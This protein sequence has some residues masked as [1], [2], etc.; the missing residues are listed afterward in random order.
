LRALPYPHGGASESRRFSRSLFAQENQNKW[1][2]I[3]NISI[4]VDHPSPTRAFFHC[5]NFARGGCG[6]A[7]L[8]VPPGNGRSMV[9]CVRLRIFGQG[10]CY[11]M[12]RKVAACKQA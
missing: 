4:V 8:V 1:L 2:Q 12:G 5:T 10:H 6:S 9:A 7:T 11:H 3:A